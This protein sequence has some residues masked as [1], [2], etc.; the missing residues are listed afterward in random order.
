M[1]DLSK[2]WRLSNLGIINQA[3][4]VDL[5]KDKKDDLILAREWNS[6]LMLLSKTTEGFSQVE[7][8][9]NNNE[10]K[11]LWNSIGILDIDSDGLLD[12]VLGNAGHN[13]A[14]KVNNTHP[15]TLYFKDFDN[16]GQTEA[17]FSK[18]YPQNKDYFLFQN[19]N[20]ISLQWP[21]IL[22]KYPS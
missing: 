4:V 6:P 13:T 11:G 8:K 10:T 2:E 18:Y 7:I 15:G 21:A 12:I 1:K 20:D 9:D 17:L 19:R 5:N 3:K 22:Q 16:N 14:I